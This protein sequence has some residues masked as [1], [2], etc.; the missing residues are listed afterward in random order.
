M[1]DYTPI[2]IDMPI[3]PKFI[4]VDF[5]VHPDDV[6]DGW[7][8]QTDAEMLARE[9]ELSELY[10]SEAPESFS[11]VFPQHMVPRSEWKERAERTMAKFRGVAAPIVSQGREGSCV[12]FSCANALMNTMI[13]RFGRRNWVDLSGVSLYKRIGRSAA[14]GAYIPDGMRELKDRGVLPVNSS[15]NMAK[16]AHTHPRTGFSMALPNGWTNTGKLF[17]ASRIVTCRGINEIAS[18]LLGGFVGVV[19]RSR[20]AIN[21]IYLTFDSRGNFVVCYANSWGASWG[22]QGFGFDSESTVRNLTMYVVLDIVTRPDIFI[23]EL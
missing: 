4:D 13:R 17:R 5:T 8:E 20:H 10:G 21:Y 7:L 19:G 11:S 22:Q 9:E 3:D 1:M 2:Y 23:P 16:Y 15:D 6:G 18:A 14:S 12:G